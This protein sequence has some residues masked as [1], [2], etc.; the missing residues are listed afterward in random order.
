MPIELSFYK[1]QINCFESQDLNHTKWI[2]FFFFFFLGLLKNVSCIFHK[3]S[4]NFFIF[5]GVCFLSF[6]H[7]FSY[8]TLSK[9]KMDDTPIY[10][11]CQFHTF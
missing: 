2:D 1:F 10:L 7:F 3:T 6:L 5:I 11:F 9:K 4:L 8:G